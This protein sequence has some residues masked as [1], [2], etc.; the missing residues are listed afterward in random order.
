M[1]RARHD[2]RFDRRPPVDGRFRT[3]RSRRPRPDQETEAGEQTAASSGSIRGV[4]RTAGV[5]PGI[6]TSERDDADT[7][8]TSIDAIV[9][10]LRT[11]LGGVV[12]LTVIEAAVTAELDRYSAA[13]IKQDV[14]ILVE[15]RVFDQLG[16]RTR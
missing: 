4:P 11:R 8:P 12:D 5:T 1:P 7:R 10:S 3:R 16:S 14:P 9:E 15:R 2:R 13:P 6:Q